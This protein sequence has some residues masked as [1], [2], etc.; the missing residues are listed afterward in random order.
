MPPLGFNNTFTI[1]VRSSDAQS[2]KLRTIDDL[3]P[4]A[5]RWTPGFGYEF[6][7]RDDGY[8]GLV[9]RLRSCRLPKSRKAWT[10]R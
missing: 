10:C 7:D 9:R 2:M 1:L 8:A 5:G 4:L 6:L 3:K